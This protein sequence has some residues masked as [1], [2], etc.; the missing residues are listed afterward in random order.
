MGLGMQFM[1]AVVPQVGCGGGGQVTPAAQAPPDPLHQLDSLTFTH[2]YR[3]STQSLSVTHVTGT[4]VHTD[5]PGVQVSPVVVTVPSGAL[6]APPVQSRALG[7]ADQ[8]RRTVGGC[9]ARLRLGRRSRWCSSAAVVGRTSC[10]HGH[11]E[12][13]AVM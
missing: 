2:W 10:P 13:G 5:G 8:R 6:V 3:G 9:A 1:I 4:Q 7:L 12:A 11:G